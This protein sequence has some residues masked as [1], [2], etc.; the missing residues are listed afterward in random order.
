MTYSFLRIFYDLYECHFLFLTNCHITYPLFVS[1][2]VVRWTS[3]IFTPPL[4]SRKCRTKVRVRDPIEKAHDL[5]TE[6][7][8]TEDRISSICRMVARPQA[9]TNHG[10]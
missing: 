5:H 2:F 3:C 10:H 4:D 6:N 1:L 9:K 7:H 8:D